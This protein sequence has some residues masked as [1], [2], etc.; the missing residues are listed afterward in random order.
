ME[1]LS[2]EYGGTPDQI[3]KQKL[4]DVKDYIEI[5]MMRN[6][7]IASEYKKIGKK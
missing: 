1:M 4:K 6:L 2:K 3:G 7:L 5:I